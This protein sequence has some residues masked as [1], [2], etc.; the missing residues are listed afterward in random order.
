MEKLIVVK[1]SGRMRASA[2]FCS[3]LDLQKQVPAQVEGRGPET[4]L[5]KGKES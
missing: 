5:N 4:L 3:A 1:G 2:G